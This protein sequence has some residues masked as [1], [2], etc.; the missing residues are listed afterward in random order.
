MPGTKK[1]DA[2]PEAWRKQFWSGDA[3]PD[4]AKPDDAT[5][6]SKGNGADSDGWGEPDMGVLRLRRRPPPALP[7]EVSARLGNNGF[8]TRPP[9]RPVR[10]IMSSRRC[11]PAPRR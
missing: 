9:P 5:A 11:S 10:S 8:L 7:L 2:D 6:K 1:F 3:G 4:N